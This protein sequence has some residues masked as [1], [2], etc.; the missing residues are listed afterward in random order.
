[1]TNV[2]PIVDWSFAG[3][4]LLRLLYTFHAWHR[5]RKLVQAGSLAV[6]LDVALNSRSGRWSLSIS[7]FFC[8]GTPLL[9]NLLQWD[10]RQPLILAGVLLGLSGIPILLRPPVVLVLG[11]STDITQDLIVT[12]NR[13]VVPK[14][15]IGLFDWEGKMDS[16]L[17]PALLTRDNF[18]TS[19]EVPWGPVVLKL[20][21]IVPIVIVD[22]R[23]PS[24]PVIEETRWM[25]Q[26]ENR[27]KA[28]FFAKSKGATPSLEAIG[29]HSGTDEHNSL[30]V[31][32]D[33]DTLTDIL[34]D[35]AKESSK[36][37]S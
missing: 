20:I 1:M 31:V 4:A 13:T 33:Y 3:F 16:P 14:R 37:N 5:T 28:V 22:T 2:V 29:I 30:C 15:V 11:S 21:R 12:T 19:E 8:F 9:V 32:Q 26:P 17:L 6:M 10:G 18:R 35:P 7:A 24:P 23:I 36:C 27:S 34:T 25:V